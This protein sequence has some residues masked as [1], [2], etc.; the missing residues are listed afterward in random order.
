MIDCRNYALRLITHK[1]R[2]EKELRTKLNEKGYDENTIEDEIAFLKDYGYIDDKRYAKNFTADAI[3][4]KK[5]GKVRIRTELLRRGVDAE[6]TDNSIAD[7]F[8]E[9]CSDKVLEQLES[10]FK[11][12]DLSNLKERTR[13]FNY[14]FRRG[15]TAEEIKGA[16]NR[17]CSFRDVITEEY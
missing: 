6:I 2:T 14:F 17:V 7:A 15:Y 13:I 9:D 11:N 10:R 8:P 4:L 12:S 3:N 16:M 1:D 5:W